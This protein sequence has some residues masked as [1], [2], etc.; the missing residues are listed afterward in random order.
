MR[1]QTA[2]LVALGAALMGASPAHAGVDE[3]YAGVIYHNACVLDCKNANKEG[4]PNVEAEIVFDSPQMLHWLGS[5][6]PYIMGSLN[7]QG[8]TSFGGFGLNWSW[9]FADKWSIDPGVGYVV[10]NGELENPYTPGTAQ[11]TQFAEEHVLLGSRDL[12]RTSLGITRHMDG[13]WAVQGFYEHLSHGQI[14]GHGRNQGLDQFGIRVAY[15]FG[16]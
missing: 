12:F 7:T 8:D 13:P 6:R 16:E 11:S 9:H 14:L 2:G 3:I 4:E 15:E 1:G 5:P 10:H